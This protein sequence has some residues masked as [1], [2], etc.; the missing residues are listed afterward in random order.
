M[1]LN[2][3]LGETDRL[4]DDAVEHLVMPHIDMANIACGFHAG[5]SQVAKQTIELAKKHKVAIGAHPSYPDREN[6]GR[7]SMQLSKADICDLVYQQIRLI[8]ALSDDLAHP[9]SYIKPHGALY[10]DMMVSDEVLHGVF[11]ATRALD[12]KM[13]LMVMSTLNN[14][15]ITDKAHTFGITLIFEAFADRR[16]DNHGRLASRH[17]DGA[18]INSQHDITHQAKAL[19]EGNDILSINQ[20]PLRITAESL[21]VHG[22]NPESIAAIATIK[23]ALSK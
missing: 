3:D 10:N 16:Y 22:D 23:S 5:N 19:A 12:S 8:D 4:T 1:K 14:Q 11:E 13:P 18:V 7:L 17:L 21:C 15:A 9:M 2:C 20:K 6:F